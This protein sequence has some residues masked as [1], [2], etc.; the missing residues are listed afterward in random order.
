MFFSDSSCSK[1]QGSLSLGLYLLFVALKYSALCDVLLCTLINS[2]QYISTSSP[3]SFL[4][5][6]TMTLYVCFHNRKLMPMLAAMYLRNLRIMP[7]Q[8]C[9]H[10]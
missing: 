6:N 8:S 10:T 4:T 2:A 9:F 3:S 5:G 1:M 7:V